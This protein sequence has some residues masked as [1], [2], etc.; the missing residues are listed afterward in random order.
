MSTMK[1]PLAVV[2]VFVT[3]GSLAIWWLNTIFHYENRELVSLTGFIFVL[4]SLIL[5]FFS[6]RAQ[7]RSNDVGRHMT[8]CTGR[9]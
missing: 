4:S 6:S 2:A 5:V 3:F 1:R 7:G 8:S 9:L